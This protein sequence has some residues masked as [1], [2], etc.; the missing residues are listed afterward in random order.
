MSLNRRHFLAASAA[1]PLAGRAIAAV[2]DPVVRTSHGPVRGLAENG[3]LVFRGV[4]YG[5]DTALTRFGKPRR[6]DPWTDIV[7]VVEYGASAPQR[8]GEADQSEDCLFLNVWTPGLGDGALRPVMVYIHGGAYNSGS[9]SDALYDGAR[10]AAK[11]DVVVITVN[12][13]LNAFGYLYLEAVLPGLFPDSGNAGQWDLVLALEW[14]RGNAAAFGGD[15]SRVMLFGQSG[16]GAK[17]ATLMASPAAA[18]LFHSAA[19]MSGQQ[20]TASGP[21]NA[22]R[23]TKAFLSALKLGP[24]DAGTI[25]TL[26]AARIVEALGARDPLDE[27]QGLYFGPVLDER[28]LTRHPFWPDAPP[29]SARIPMILGNTLDETRTLIGRREPEMFDLG[30]D[31]L[32]AALARHMRTDIDPGTVVAAYRAAY[33]ER[34]PGDVFFAATTAGRSWRGQVEE[35]DA[36][37]RQGA[38][39]WVYRFD[40]PWSEDGGKWGAPHTADIGYVFGNLDK[41]DA[42]PGEA[43]AA[44]RVSDEISGAFAALARSG[45]PEHTRLARWPTYRLPARETML[46]DAE[47]QMARDP[48]GVERA[49]FSKVP[50]IQWGS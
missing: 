11:G 37:A 42:M 41:A 47:T 50:F 16:G 43:A 6:P 29:Q 26:P 13:R 40:L 21:L 17:I 44:R 48:R 23:R 38:P 35:A 30:W 20:V 22:A 2:G 14:V 33:P 3:V 46:F 36:R 1:L 12:H 7:R 18:G 25:A 32:P 39:T 27:T 5:A 31:A 8:G 10:L 49:L 34:S 19:T 9:G 45:S 15:P 28:M 4:R 24:D